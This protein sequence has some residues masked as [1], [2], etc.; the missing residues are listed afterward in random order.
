MDVKNNL[1]KAGL[2]LREEVVQEEAYDFH[3]PIRYES[4]NVKMITIDGYS[5][6]KKFIFAVPDSV[7]KNIL[8]EQAKKIKAKTFC[9]GLKFDNTSSLSALKNNEM[10]DNN[11]I[12]LMLE[13]DSIDNVQSLDAYLPF[14]NAENKDSEDWNAQPSHLTT[15]EKEISDHI[16]KLTDEMGCSYSDI[17]KS[18]IQ[19]LSLLLMYKHV[20]SNF[21]LKLCLEYEKKNEPELYKE[22]TAGIFWTRTDDLLNKILGHEKHSVTPRP[23]PLHRWKM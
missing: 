10:L 5:S 18:K 15:E 13:F 19:F 7:I 23:L 16:E 3:M 22:A 12:A 4:K 9:L 17:K 20:N 21:S 6:F 11:A 1:S 8:F 14:F 2:G